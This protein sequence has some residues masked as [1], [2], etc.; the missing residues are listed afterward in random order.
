MAEKL[1][2]ST[3]TVSFMT[4]LSRIVGFVRDM[5]IANF[6]GATGSVDAFL[7]AF[8]IPNFMRRLFAEGAFSQAFVPVL[9]DYKTHH[10]PKQVQDFISKVF[11]GLAAV[12][13]LL[14]I[15]GVVGAPWLI[16]IF[17]PGFPTDGQRFLLASQL[18]QLTFPYILFISLTA[19]A[20][21]VQNAYGKFAIPAFTPV[22]L[23]ISLIGAAFWIAP[24]CGA[25]PIQSLAWGVLI[26]GVAQLLFQIPFLIKLSLMPRLVLNWRSPEVTRV[27]KLMGPALLGGSVL[28]INLLID[29]VFASFLPMGSLT[30]IYYSDRLLEF[31]IGVFGVALAT[32]VLPHLSHKYAEKNQTEFSASI[33]WALRWILLIGLPAT[34]GL[35]LLAGPILATLFQ[36][37]RFSP[38]DVVMASKSLMTLSL[39]LTCF[40]AVKI[41]V[42]AFYARQN[43]AFPVKVAIVAVGV[44]VACNAL[45][46]GPM[47]HAGL[48]LASSIASLLNVSVL[49]VALIRRKIY[50]PLQGWQGFGLR[51]LIAN[52]MMGLFLWWF[53]PPIAQWFA[54]DAME[55]AWSLLGCIAG[56]GLI[57]FASLWITGLRYAHMRIENA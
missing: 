12:L 25:N 56:A 43:T 8:K 39:G 3:T 21:G 34:V 7:L 23:N 16:R 4:F 52:S 54:W 33:D 6:F 53:S 57:Y 14:T 48:T 10:D 17:A 40:L 31:P 1:L 30:W 51:I 38:F 11:C 46:I 22:L 15:L 2:K 35:V 13:L 42:S 28:Q 18:L 47:A 32:V 55:R 29:T 49:L 50:C 41:L 20:A 24:L 37:G 36:Y 27:L 26:A 5:V 19:F 45:L 44:N 9:S